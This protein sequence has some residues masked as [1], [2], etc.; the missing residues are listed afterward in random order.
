[1][2]TQIRYS[3]SSTRGTSR[4]NIF[5]QLNHKTSKCR[6]DYCY[7]P[8]RIRDKSSWASKVEKK[9]RGDEKPGLY[10]PFLNEYRFGS[11]IPVIK[12]L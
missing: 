6:A 10:I 9:E 1:M 5:D 3:S 7:R 12:Y 8:K 4:E 11:P 2:V